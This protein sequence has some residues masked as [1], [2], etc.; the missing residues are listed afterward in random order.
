MNECGQQKVLTSTGKVSMCV[1]VLGQWLS[2]CVSAVLWERQEIPQ[3]T[4]EIYF[5]LPASRCPCFYILEPLGTL[6]RVHDAIA[7]RI[8]PVYYSERNMKIFSKATVL[9]PEANLLLF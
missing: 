3:R 7:G 6:N 5:F 1:Y 4:E 9:K 2:V 8:L